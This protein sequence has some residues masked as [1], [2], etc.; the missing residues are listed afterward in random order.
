MLRTFGNIKNRLLNYLHLPYYV[1]GFVYIVKVLI[2]FVVKP[3]YEFD[4][5][6][7]TQISKQ[8]PT[9]LLDSV[10]VD[11]HPPGFYFLLKFFP[12]ENVLYSKLLILTL[13]FALFVLVIV[14]VY[15]SF[16]RSRALMIGLALFFASYSF[17]SI[18]SVLKQDSLSLPILLMIFFMALKFVESRKVRREEITLINLL[19][20][21]LLFLGYVNYLYAVLII[22]ATFFVFKKDKYGQKLIF[23]Q[24][25]VFGL[26]IYL[27]GFTQLINN[28]QR[29]S[30]VSEIPNSIISSLNFHLTGFTKFNFWSDSVLFA[31]F[32]FIFYFVSNTKKAKLKG[33]STAF[34]VLLVCLIIS[35][36]YL[37]K[38]YVRVRYIVFLY[39]LLTFICGL[40]IFR[41]SSKFPNFRKYFISIFIFYLLSN[42]FVYASN[43]AL[44]QRGENTVVAILNDTAIKT[45]RLGY[46]TDYNLGT[47]VF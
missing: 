7:L 29:F 24:L 8:A 44:T 25:L 6:I 38:L 1:L 22:A 11:P 35:L 2:L 45:D 43:L 17:F 3:V 28:T 46:V 13:S 20:L 36:G 26:Y 19:S 34:I 42:T 18:P 37:A 32:G 4:E 14:Y 12:V 33:V 30:L 31:I 10:S 15:R 9:K 27:F 21:I 5:V 47:M 23:L 16:T 39:F 40:V 41:L